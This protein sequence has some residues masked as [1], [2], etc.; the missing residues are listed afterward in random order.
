MVIA[1]LRRLL[2]IVVKTQFW[3]DASALFSL[4]MGCEQSVYAEEEYD[5]LD[6]VHVALTAV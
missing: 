5:R 1:T 3:S 6:L 4:L 2:F